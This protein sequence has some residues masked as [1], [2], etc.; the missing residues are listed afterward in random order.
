MD[1]P[2]VTDT[3]DAGDVV[4]PWV[5][6]DD[7]VEVKTEEPLA[8]YLVEGRSLAGAAAEHEEHSRYALAVAMFHRN[9]AGELKTQAS[10]KAVGPSCCMLELE[11]AH[12]R[13]A[14]DA[15]KQVDAFH[16]EHGSPKTRVLLP[17]LGTVFEAVKASS[18]A[19][20]ENLDK[21]SRV[22]AGE[23]GPK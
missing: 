9:K 12:T 19:L 7:L 21:L 2:K 22:L 23:K 1:T 20:G 11:A 8:L 17:L 10:I 14:Q 6:P 5:R 18:D 15:A 16:Q 4:E 3:M 13:A